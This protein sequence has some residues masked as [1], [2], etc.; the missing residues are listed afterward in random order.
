MLAQL[1]A[2]GQYGQLELR[3]SGSGSEKLAPTREFEPNSDSLA[4]LGSGSRWPGR[5]ETESGS[6]S[7]SLPESLHSGLA[8]RARRGLVLLVIT[9][10]GARATGTQ[11]EAQAG[12]ASASDS[13]ST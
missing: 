12:S 5:S 11:P 10:H 1:E 2:P 3:G 8:D 4:G 13:S 6:G 7:G 9:S